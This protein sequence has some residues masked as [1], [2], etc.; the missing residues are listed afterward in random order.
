MVAQALGV[1]NFYFW[2]T[3]NYF[4]GQNLEKPL[5]HT[6]SLAVEEQFYLLFPLLLIFLFRHAV[7]RRRVSLLGVFLLMAVVSLALS[8]WGVIHQPYATFFLLPTRAWELLSGSMIAVLPAAWHLRMKIWREFACLLGLVGILIP[9]FAYTEETPFPGLAALSP[10]LGASLVIW[11]C[12]RCDDGRGTWCAHILAWRPVVFIGLIS[13][14]LYLWHWPVLVFANYWKTEPFSPMIK[15]SLCLAS[16]LLAILSWRFVEKPF[17]R[18]RGSVDSLRGVMYGAFASSLLMSSL[19]V[20]YFVK[21]GF[22]SRLPHDARIL[23]EKAS[24]RQIR[25]HRNGGNIKFPNP[26]EIRQG[27][28]PCLGVTSGTNKTSQFLVWGDSHAEV[29]LPAYNALG[30][31]LGI[32]GK[33]LIVYSTPPLIGSSSQLKFESSSKA[34]IAEAAIDFIREKQVKYVFLQGYWAL[35]QKSMGSQKLE[36]EIKKTVKRLN[37]AGATVL[38][39]QD[40][41]SYEINILKLLIR[42]KFPGFSE[43]FSSSGT[44]KDHADRNSAIYKIASDKVNAIFLDPAPLFLDPTFKHYLI[45]EH[46]VPYYYDENHITSNSAM[47]FIYP[48]LK[49][50]FIHTSVK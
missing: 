43:R 25:R 44:L 41:P 24:Q 12:V 45:S 10:C 21:E 37:D 19:G 20:S 46:G 11:G 33:A 27:V 14:S 4:G 15:T 26:N 7:L 48:L 35:Y 30:K 3:T 8:V 50:R 9:I 42:D 23:L 13:Y 29:A 39:M 47:K 49:S 18:S 5:L 6:W 34:E 31:D 36:N 22:P 32:T 2:R 16:L 38:I 17:R 1:S 40:V 28:M